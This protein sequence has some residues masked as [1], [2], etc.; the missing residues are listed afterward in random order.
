VHP[1]GQFVYVTSFG[2][3]H[4]NNSGYVF[5]FTIDGATGALTAIPGSPFPAGEGPW[6][7]TVDATGRF[8]YVANAF[9]LGRSEISAYTIDATTGALAAV[10]GSSFPGWGVSGVAATAGPAPP[11]SSDRVM[12]K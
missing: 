11:L 1:T 12:K 9:S 3:G 6:S 10:P 2:D 7:A 4:G 5:A 8:L